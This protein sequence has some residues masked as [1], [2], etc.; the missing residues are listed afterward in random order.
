MVR[1]N[2]Q[3]VEATGIGPMSTVD[4]FPAWTLG[5]PSQT[6][7]NYFKVPADQLGS[8]GVG[9]FEFEFV[10][11]PLGGG[12][13][14]VS[15]EDD[16]LSNPGNDYDYGIIMSRGH[17]DDNADPPVMY[18]PTVLIQKRDERNCS[19]HCLDLVFSVVWGYN[20]ETGAQIK[21]VKYEL[22]TGWEE[23]ATPQPKYVRVVRRG[24]MLSMH[25]AENRD[26]VTNP[27]SSVGT[28]FML[29]QN[30]A[31]DIS[32]FDK[33]IEGSDAE[34]MQQPRQHLP[35]LTAGRSRE[36]A[37]AWRWWCVGNSNPSG[38]YRPLGQVAILRCGGARQGTGEGGEREFFRFFM[39]F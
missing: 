11:G 2:G 35:S 37:W 12:T 15:S 33:Q 7:S 6:E 16:Y 22:P 26:L 17:L 23:S 13:D 1:F 4:S 10:L 32:R 8:W 21:G 18:G 39:F 29:N 9:D 25:V 34:P 24:P 28:P 3:S 20:P 27:T 36:E 31:S 30:D 19:S 14:V 38:S 5:K